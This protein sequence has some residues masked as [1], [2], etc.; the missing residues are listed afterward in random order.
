MGLIIAFPMQLVFWYYLIYTKYECMPYMSIKPYHRHS[1]TEHII[2][3][4]TAHID[5][6]KTA[7]SYWN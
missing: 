5:Y 6:G 3:M 7:E 4:W 1:G 2:V